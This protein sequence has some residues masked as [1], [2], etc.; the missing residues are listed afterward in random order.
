MFPR[1]TC[2]VFHPANDT[3]ADEGYVRQ[4]NEWQACERASL[5]RTRG[6]QIPQAGL[7]GLGH[8]VTIPSRKKARAQALAALFLCGLGAPPLAPARVRPFGFWLQPSARGRSPKKV[9]S[10]AGHGLTAFDIIGD[11][12]DMPDHWEAERIH[13]GSHEPILG[14]AWLCCRIKSLRAA[15]PLGGPVRRP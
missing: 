9:A 6:P 1:M 3:N 7:A 14:A 2:A 15:S 12:E 11:R 10:N 8:P 13:R 5:V 4:P